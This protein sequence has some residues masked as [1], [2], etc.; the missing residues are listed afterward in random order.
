VR[1][2]DRWRVSGGPG[3]G[4]ISALAPGTVYHYRLLATTAAGTSAGADASFRTAPLPRHFKPDPTMIWMI[5]LRPLYTVIASLSSGNA[6]AGAKIVVRCAGLGCLFS[7]QT[8]RV[9][10]VRSSTAKGKFHRC[11]LI[12]SPRRIDLTPLFAHAHLAPG[13]RVTV[14]FVKP[15]YVGKICPFNIRSGPQPTV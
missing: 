11:R 12:R 7:S 8:I 3:V 2:A 13:T 4:K 5:T 14:S 9:T 10:P 1:T 6:P 15:G